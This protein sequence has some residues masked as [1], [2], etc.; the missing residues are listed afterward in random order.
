MII[1]DPMPTSLMCD[2]G[3]F[4]AWRQ[5]NPIDLKEYIKYIKRN[6]KFLTSYVALDTIPGK[7]GK[8]DKS[9]EALEFSA[10][11]SFKNLQIMRDKGLSPIPVFHQGEQFKW[12]EK[13]LDAGEPYIGISPYL[14]AHRND[15]RRWLDDC[16][17]LVTDSKGR[18]LVKTHGFGVT[19]TLLCTQFP[20]FSTDSTSW[21]TAAGYGNFD[22]PSYSNGKF[23][24]TTQPI[25]FHIT[26]RDELGLGG[27]KSFDAL[28][29][30]EREA[31]LR[32]F[33]LVGVTVTEVRNSPTHRW[34][35][36][37]RYYQELEKHCTCWTFQ[38]RSNKFLL[39]TLSQRQSE[40]KPWKTM[41]LIFS[42]TARSMQHQRILNLFK[43]KNRLLSYYQLKDLPD[44]TVEYYSKTGLLHKDEGRPDRSNWSE[45][46]AIRRRL[47][48]AN[49]YPD[50]KAS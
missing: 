6:E 3:A 18:P 46:Y 17:S 31:V 15:I 12:L 36:R 27:P 34:H 39:N 47:A 30:Q 21:A 45:T 37:I 50:T 38:R 41:T 33:D 9:A 16:F 28:Q 5:N 22:V 13:L 11:E 1:A 29:E 19:S 25:N 7:S 24:Y 4:S 14:R 20:W 8:I 43:V 2:S 35:V 32:F 23:D 10:R 26:N 49:R 42:S 44:E 40:L 48:L